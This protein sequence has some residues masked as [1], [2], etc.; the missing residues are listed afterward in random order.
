MILSQSAPREEVNTSLRTM[1]L[2]QCVNMYKIYSTPRHIVMND[3]VKRV[4]DVIDLMA[5]VYA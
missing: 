5:I 1:F 3:S 4:Y 2:K